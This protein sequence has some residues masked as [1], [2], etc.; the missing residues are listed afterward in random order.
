MPEASPAQAQ[1]DV[2]WLSVCAPSGLTDQEKIHIPVRVFARH[3]LISE[4]AST[5]KAHK[6]RGSAFVA[7][8]P[9]LVQG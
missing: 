8:K 2:P 9:R 6:F 1:L 4:T 7:R 5:A 3:K